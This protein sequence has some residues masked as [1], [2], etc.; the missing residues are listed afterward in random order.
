MGDLDSGSRP[1]KHQYC[2]I[3]MLS[4]PSQPSA[5]L[6]NAQHFCSLILVTICAQLHLNLL[7]CGGWKCIGM[8]IS[9]PLTFD[10]VLFYVPNPLIDRQECYRMLIF[11][12]FFPHLDI[13]W[14]TREVPVGRRLNKGWEKKSLFSS[15][16]TF[17]FSFISTPI[18]WITFRTT[19]SSWRQFAPHMPV[20]GRRNN[21][22]FIR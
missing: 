14:S 2:S 15:F 20:N 13:T 10:T 4:F 5:L 6:F 12:Y 22:I 19:Q 7:F 11:V 1:S 8:I 17:H 16:L 18:G 21:R 3:S 9:P